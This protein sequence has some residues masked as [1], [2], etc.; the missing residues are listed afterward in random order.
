MMYADKRRTA[1][2]NDIQK[3]DEVLLKQDRQNKLT[4]T[5][6]EEPYKVMG[7]TGN[8]VVIEQNGV[9]YK[10]NVTHVKRH[11]K[12]PYR[13]DRDESNVHANNGETVNI[14]VEK[15]SYDSDNGKDREDRDDDIRPSEATEN[16]SANT[17]KVPSSNY[18]PMPT[19]A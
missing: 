6:R 3:G 5:F 14:D 19:V 2:E 1:R 4:P 9:Q 18:I 7:K 15:V 10:R 12:R 11:R 13:Q 16:A 17:A 8:A